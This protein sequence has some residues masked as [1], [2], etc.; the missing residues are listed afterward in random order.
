MTKSELIKTV[1]SA[2]GVPEDISKKDVQVLIEVMFDEIK[3]T[4]KK[5]DSFRFPGFGTFNKKKRAA[6]E[7]R[8][9]QTGDAMKIK[10]STTVTF[11]PAQDLKDFMSGKK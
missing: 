9:P 1:L 10:A 6:R 4:I 5:D 11:K 8:N 3:K 7:G 2:K